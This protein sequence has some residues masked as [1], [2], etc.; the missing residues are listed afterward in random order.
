MST[1][2]GL[3]LPSGEE[4]VVAGPTVAVG[5][6]HPGQVE[7]AFHTSLV[8]LF[9]ADAYGPRL[10]QRHYPSHSGANIVSGRNKMVREFLEQGD[11]DWLWI[12]DSDMAFEADTLYA[13]YLVSDKMPDDP[14]YPF[15]AYALMFTIFRGELDIESVVVRVDD[16][17]YIV[18]LDFLGGMPLDFYFQQKAADL[19]DPPPETI[20]FSSEAAEIFVYPPEMQPEAGGDG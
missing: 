12:L 15:G 5:Y 6:L 18:R 11:E 7:G 16:E 1:H 19:M 9:M 3:L 4:E 13:A 14:E 8:H 20:M 10:I 2:E 17:G